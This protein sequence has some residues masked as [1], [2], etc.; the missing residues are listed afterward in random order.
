MVASGLLLTLSAGVLVAGPASGPAGASSHVDSITT[1]LDNQMDS[2]DL[3]AFTSPEKPDT[4]TVVA[5]Y[6]GLQPPVLPIPWA[7]SDA[8]YDI[9]IDGTGD[10]RPD[11][12]YRFTFR[13]EDGSEAP[14]TAPVDPAVL[15]TFAQY[16]KAGRTREAAKLAAEVRRK[17]LIIPQLYT[18]QEVRPGKPAKTL[19]GKGTVNATK[20]DNI[21]DFSKKQKEAVAPWAGGGSSYVGHSKDPFFFDIRMLSLLRIGNPIA[22]PVDLFIPFNVNTLAIQVPKKDLALKGDAKRNPVIG[23]WTASYRKNLNLS[24]GPDTWRQVGRLGNAQWVDS[25]V[26]FAGDRFNTTPPTEDRDHKSMMDLAAAPPAAFLLQAGTLTQAPPSPRKDLK[27]IFLNG[28][29][30]AG[31]GPVKEDLNAHSLNHDADPKAIVAAEE[32]RLNMATPVTARPKQFGWLDGDKQG[33]PNGRR[34]TDDVTTISARWLMGE[35]VYRRPGLLDLL[36]FTPVSG[37][38]KPPGKAFPYVQPPDLRF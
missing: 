19:V 1:V 21:L 31:T 6:M 7:I 22:P 33:F 11:L 16:R 20:L 28:F 35:P 23:V 37:A 17:R 9:N 5:D 18:L 30:K 8:R 4:V 27:Q 14:R 38:I 29:S 26:R 13:N 34:L 10:G 2:S 12:T 36:T 24:G 32:L 15:A 3:Y 25:V